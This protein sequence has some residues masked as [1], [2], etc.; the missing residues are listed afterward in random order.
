MDY[1]RFLEIVQA[2]IGGDRDRAERATRAV[3]QTLGERIERGEARDLAVRMPPE[4]APYIAAGARGEPFDAEEFVRRVAEREDVDARTAERDARVVLAAL[5]QV[6]GPDEL[7]DLAAQLPMDFATVLPRGRPGPVVQSGAFLRRVA[8]RAG[9]D[10][11]GARRATDAVLETLGERIAEGEIQDLESRLPPTLH[12]PLDR[13]NEH[14]DGSATRMPVLA[15]LTRIAERERISGAEAARRA[16]AVLLTLREAVRD[17]E[18]FDTTVQL[19]DDYSSL[20]R[21]R[22]R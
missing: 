14:T 8:E 7:D 3:L 22:R 12:E 18:F 13:G 21:A 16:R 9:L 15:F 19:G 10:V 1:E 4:L 11:E 5:G 6:V 20:V 2:E 17:D